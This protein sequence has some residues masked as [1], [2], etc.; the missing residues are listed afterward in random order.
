MGKQHLTLILLTTRIWRAPNNTSKW[1]MGFNLEFKGLMAFSWWGEH[2]AGKYLEFLV[3]LYN[4][5]QFT[6]ITF[7]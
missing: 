2:G 7:F 3:F 5:M 6:R 4:G 1:Q